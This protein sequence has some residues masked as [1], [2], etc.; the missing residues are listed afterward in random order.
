MCF[1]FSVD[2]DMI[3]ASAMVNSNSILCTFILRKKLRKRER[4]GE[5]GREG[6]RERERKRESKR[7]R[8][9]ERERERERGIT[10]GQWQ[11]LLWQLNVSD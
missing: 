1:R 5:T 11:Q 3:T 6:G 8:E 4:E 7:E 10:K 2:V 9:S